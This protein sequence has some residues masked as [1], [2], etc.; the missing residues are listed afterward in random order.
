MVPISDE[1]PAELRPVITV[2]LIL[3]NVCAWFTLQGAGTDAALE[4]SVVHFGTIPCEVTAAC[5]TQGLGWETVLTSMFMH[6]SWEHIIGNLLF[7]WVFGNNI[8]DSMGHLRFLIF[9]LLCGAVAAAAHIYFNLASGVPAVGASGAISGVMGAYIVLYPKARV[10]TWFPPIFLFNIR[11]MFFLAYWFLLQLFM[12]YVE[13]GSEAGDGSGVAVWAHVGGFVAGVAL[14]KLFEN[15]ALTSARRN[16][17][18]LT[19]AEVAR[20]HPWM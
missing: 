8:E 9:Y 3:V 1:N 15:R 5:A 17:V 16:G 6:G 14:I 7:L 10:R 20:A 2:A 18:Q 4:A 11:A 19:R 13:F 12:A